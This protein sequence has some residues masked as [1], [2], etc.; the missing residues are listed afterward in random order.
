MKRLQISLQPELDEELGRV[1]AEQGISKAEVVRRFLSSGFATMPRL[2]EDPVVRL[3]GSFDGGAPDDSERHDE[4][5]YGE[6]S[7]WDP[8]RWDRRGA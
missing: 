3:F 1:A 8:E 5:I 4:V 2:D 6:P 7:S